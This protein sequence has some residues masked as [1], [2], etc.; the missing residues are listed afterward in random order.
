MGEPKL[1]IQ[2]L[3]NRD[4]H[5]EIFELKSA[6][7][8]LFTDIANHFPQSQLSDMYP[9]SKGCKVSM[10]NELGHCPY[11]V[12]DI[13]RDFDKTHGHNIRVLNWWGHGLFVLV[14]FGEKFGKE[15]VEKKKAAK[16]LENGFILP[17][18]KNPY[19]YANFFKQLSGTPTPILSCEEHISKFRYLQFAKKLEMSGSMGNLKSQVLEELE[20]ILRFCRI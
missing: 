6:F 17:K 5:E 13:F 4:I 19:D 15:L 1:N 14:F 2:L 8:H 16:F 20:R 7:K 10:G 11:Q 9:E 18:G 12:L 3:Q